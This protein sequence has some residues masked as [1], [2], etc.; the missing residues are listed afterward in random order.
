MVLAVALA[1]AVSGAEAPVFAAAGASERV[2]EH[3]YDA[4][5]LPGGRA[6]R[7]GAFGL[8]S[9]TTDGGRSWQTLPSH[10]D[11]HLFSVDFADESVGW[12]V[13][14][15]G[16]ILA[17]T[18]GGN[19]WKPQ[20]SGTQNHL[21]AV[22]AISPTEAWAV[23][24]WGAIL[25]TTDGGA[26]WKDRSLE[27]DVIL[28][29]MSWVDGRHGWIAGELGAVY[30]TTD[31]GDTWTRIESASQKSLFDIHFIDRR[32]GWAVGLDGVMLRSL[33][34]GETWEVLR[35][36]PS[37]GSLE[38]MG[39]LEALKNAGLYGISVQG[40]VGIAVGDVGMVLVSRDG[41][42]TWEQEKVPEE[43]GLRWIRG[44]SMTPESTGLL[45][46]A[47]GLT[48]AVDGGKPSYPGR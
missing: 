3:L 43:W 23:G 32:R 42:A 33:D 24:D 6:W 27:E 5:V 11:E 39:F 21:F 16:L 8:I 31:G 18:D 2:I 20:A 7:V 10:T 9:R 13:G 34:G 44:V 47:G 12:T 14:R 38:A 46:G 30:R 37:I 48:I 17:T 45:V 4:E 40:D 25:H 41:G 19:T 26:T 35:G 22:A 36:N 29:A 15:A 28:N 1:A